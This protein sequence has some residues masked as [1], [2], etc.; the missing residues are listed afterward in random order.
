[1]DPERP[2]SGTPGSDLPAPYRNPW[3]ALCGDLKAVLADSGLRLRELRRRNGEGT[4]W[5]PG[6][7]PIDLAPL[8]WP[9]C[10]ALGGLALLAALLVWPGPMTDRLHQDQ[11]QAE[12]QPRLETV[13]PSAPEATQRTIPA[14]IPLQDSAD[15][16]QPADDQV[17]SF[18]AGPLPAATPQ[19]PVDPLLATFR[20]TD[21]IALLTA[22]ETDPASGLLV[23]R[24]EASFRDLPASEQTRRAELWRHQ[25]VELG[26][27]HLQLRD[28]HSGLLARDALVGTG[29]IVFSEPSDIGAHARR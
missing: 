17:P 11:P 5:H 8:F 26:Y 21:A 27:D 20:G 15:V 25:A 3:R 2:T 24:V 12:P 1:M 18:D 6:W 9:F 23:L 22:V 28:R 10:A 29:M 16:R 4:L 19:P 13:S 14:S 7:W